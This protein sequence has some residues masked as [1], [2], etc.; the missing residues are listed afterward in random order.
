MN[1]TLSGA[2][3]LIGRRLL[4]VLGGAGHSLHV[5]SR[6]A[7]TNLPAGVRLSVWNPLQGPP[8]PESLRDSD[9]IIHLAG[10]PVAQRWTAEARRRIRESRVASTRYLVEGL[11]A[12]DRPPSVLVSASAVGYYGSRGDELLDETSAPGAD[13]LAEVCVAWER[14]AQAAE[15]LGARV[16]RIRIGVV[17]DRRGGAL[18]RMLIP[19][20]LG[21]G[22]RLGSG[23]QWIPW[24]HLQDVAE[25]FRFA[26]ENSLRGAVN[27]VAPYPVTNAEFTRELARALHRPA[28]FPVPPLALKLALGEMAE[29]VLASQ[30]AVPRAAETARF[31]FQFPQLPAALRAILQEQAVR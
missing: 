17:L 4:R 31:P 10:E 8:P 13:F 9:A 6:H 30:R 16:V 12:L 29:V 27:G 7:G 14:E 23:R 28:L 22:G 25:L 26:A 11:A 3:G 21:L 18:Q 24:I 19:F 2:S 15:A 5:L 1:V 20:R